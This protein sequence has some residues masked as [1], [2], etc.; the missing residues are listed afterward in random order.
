MAAE[1]YRR[2]VPSFWTDP[3]IKGL[4]PTE[5][6]LLLYF[7]TS[8]HS[9]MI[10]L[11]HCPLVYAARES[12][13][14]EADVNAAV[15]GP[16]A[17]FLTYDFGTEEVLVHAAG[18]HQVERQLKPNDKRLIGVKRLVEAA[19]S[20]DLVAAFLTRYSDW[21]L[22]IP[23]PEV[24]ETPSPF[25]APSKPLPDDDKP[26]RRGRVHNIAGTGTVSGAGAVADIAP[27]A[28]ADQKEP[29]PPPKSGASTWLTEFG[30]YWERYVGQPN[31]PRMGKVLAPL[32]RQ[33][34]YRQV[35]ATWIGYLGEDLG[36]DGKQFASVARFAETYTAL[37]RKHA[38]EVETDGTHVPI[39]DEPEEVAA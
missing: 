27:S 20:P 3:D 34:G 8:P 11:Y 39:P 19:H 28:P 37:A 36:P 12:N 23:V 15:V 2:V 35:L 24:P 13:L 18:R 32:R 21:N 4:G 5:R 26:P 31:Y 30:K 29:E 25:E 6:L 9:N 33:H 7:V 16:L 22:G 1:S 17:P 14:P 10:G 38:Y